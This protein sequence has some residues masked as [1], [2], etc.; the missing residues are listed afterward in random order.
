MA[1]RRIPQVIDGH[2]QQIDTTDGSLPAIVVGSA[3]WYA[4][5]KGEATQSFAYRSTL[6]SLTA[7]RERL[8]GKGYWYA[9]RTQHGQL[10]KAY[11]GKPEELTRERLNKVA[12]ALGADSTPI[13]RGASPQTPPDSTTRAHEQALLATKLFIPPPAPTLVA[14][15]RLI[16]Q[17]TAGVAHAV[18]LVSAPA[19]WGKTTLL[20]TWH[21]DLSGRGYPFAW[22]SLDANDPVRFWTYVL[23][24][25]NTLCDGVS[26]TALTLL[27]SPQPPPVESVLT[28]LLN[29]LIAL[30]MDA[31]LVLDD[32]HVI[33]AQ[34]IHHA[35]T[36]LLKHL[37]PRLHLVIATRV[38]PP[39]LLARLRV[40]G[41][42]TEV[43]AADLRFT[44]EEAATFLTQAMGLPLE[45]SQVA[46]LEVRTEGWIAGLQSAALSAQGH[47]SESLGRFIDAFTGS[48]R[49]VLEYLA[50]EVLGQ[51]GEA[52]QTFLLYTSVLDHLYAP[53]CDALLTMEQREAESSGQSQRA[54]VLLEYVERANLFLIPLDKEQRWYRYHHL[55]AEVLR[56]RLQHAHPELVPELHRRASA[57]YEQ[58]EMSAE[59]VQHALAAS[60][61]EHA[62]HLIEQ[63]AL[64]LA[65]R[66]QVHRVLGWLNALP[67][68]VV[69][70]SARLCLCHAIMLMFTNQLE[71]VEVCLQDAETCVQADMPEDRARVI[72][73]WVAGVRANLALFSG[74]LARCVAFARQT[75]DLLPE[76]EVIMRAAAA[77][78]PAHAYLVSGDV[79]Q[80]S[81]DL[82]AAS[83]APVRASGDLFALLT[84]ITL[85][86]RL[87]VMQGRLRQAAITYEQV[88]Q[89]VPEQEML[90]VLVGSAGYYF[91]LGDLLHEWNK[92]DAAEHTLMQGLELVRGTLTV[93]AQV[94]TQGYMALARLQQAR[95][96]SNRALATA[97]RWANGSGLS[98]DDDLSYP[99][100]QEYLT[101]ARVRIAQGRDDPASR[102]LQDALNLL[103]RLLQDAEAKARMGSALEIL[104]LRALALD[105]QG[106]HQGALIA[107]ERAVM[108]AEPEGYT[109]IFLDEGEPMLTLLSELLATGHSARGYLHTL[110]A[111]GD[112]R[113]HGHAV[114][115]MPASAQ[116]FQKPLQPLL[117]PLSERELEV[118]SLMADGASN[119]G[120]A[121]QLM[122]AISTVKRHVSN[123]FSKLSVTSRTQAVARARE[124]ELLQ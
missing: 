117:D 120:I 102:F 76:T 29:A 59:A 69:R 28:S 82:V 83:S 14:R 53:L 31:V 26:D 10:H 110:L 74:D 75:L 111:A 33:E 42:L 39:L 93:D 56:S 12:A 107:L 96:D 50:E 112:H 23:V 34:P 37:P 4:W 121:E 103:D 118:L 90:R 1:R 61:F 95:G 7:R 104:I 77:T 36:F 55:F 24:A 9:Y 35:L 18:T 65:L 30:P 106:D 79:T 40:R 105:A 116:T 27:R 92:L 99:R 62:A 49:Y 51:Q 2:L 124:L 60:D 45:A 47:P 13:A 113:E 5:L 108:L 57:W 15:P 22:V 20:S 80:A 38:D 109:R 46:A 63:S 17:L 71:A 101:L 78:G 67:D 81:E 6:G 84:S 70:S 11:L 89:V 54:D 25:L 44:P 94:V 43:R 86:A 98:V 91:G 8:H 68:A 64:S 58:H 3:A 100:E 114:P 21:A 52:I 115:P 73:G 32:Y 88:V 97:V 19:G 66:G 16:A 87:Q 122:L 72:Q 119:A 85:L 48:N 123:V 41:A